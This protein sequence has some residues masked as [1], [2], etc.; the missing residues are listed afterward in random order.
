MSWIDKYERGQDVLVCVGERGWR[1]ASVLALVAAGRDIETLDVDPDT[2][3]E[4][5]SQ[6][7]SCRIVRIAAMGRL[8]VRPGDVLR[9][10]ARGS[11]VKPVAGASR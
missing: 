8:L 6:T 10:I 9:V 2:R 5:R 4:I 11:A 3:T 7:R 1:R